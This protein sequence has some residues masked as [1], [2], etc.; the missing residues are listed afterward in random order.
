M[1]FSF[2]KIAD[3]KFVLKQNMKKKETSWEVGINKT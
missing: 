2:S 3:I 1:L